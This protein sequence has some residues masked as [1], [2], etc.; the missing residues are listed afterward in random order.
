[1]ETEPKL[2]PAYKRVTVQGV[3][4]VT[5]IKRLR[6]KIKANEDKFESTV[7]AF[8]KIRTILA[9]RLAEAEKGEQE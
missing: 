2:T 4:H 8:L 5:T 6:E 3:T 9:A 1:M 7:A